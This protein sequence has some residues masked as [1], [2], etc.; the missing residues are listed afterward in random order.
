M[1][2]GQTPFPTLLFS[3][4]H[5]RA[6]RVRGQSGRTWWSVGTDRGG[7]SPA[8][9]PSGGS[10]GWG[11]VFWPLSGVGL[12]SCEWCRHPHDLF[13]LFISMTDNSCWL[14]NIVIKRTWEIALHF[15]NSFSCWAIGWTQKSF[16]EEERIRA[17]DTVPSQYLAVQDNST[18]IQTTYNTNYCP[19]KSNIDRWVHEEIRTTIFWTRGKSDYQWQYF[20]GVKAAITSI[21]SQIETY[22]S[23]LSTPPQ[24]LTEI[25]YNFL[26]ENHVIDHTPLPVLQIKLQTHEVTNTPSLQS[27]RTYY[28][29]AYVTETKQKTK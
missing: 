15:I 18:E 21:L 19:S 9:W 23:S 17:V 14:L 11:L 24:T 26:S 27:K 4:K 3:F 2:S 28:W 6:L 25:Y 29:H 12:P 8:V 16:S 10:S 13:I 22:L 7:K 5:T 1:D 20:T